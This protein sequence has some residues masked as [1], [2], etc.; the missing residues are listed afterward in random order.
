MV[1]GKE[2]KLPD[3][4]CFSESFLYWIPRN[5]EHEITTLIYIND[6]LGDDVSNLF[7]ECREI[8]WIRNPLAREFETGV[9]LCTN[10]CSSFNELWHRR[11]QQVTNPFYH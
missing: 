1:L 5:P 7:S 11:V 10:P 3:P 4:A 9:W 2:Y 6:K 8:G